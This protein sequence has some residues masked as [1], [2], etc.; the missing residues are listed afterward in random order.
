MITPSRTH[1]VATSWDQAA[2]V[3]SI[4]GQRFNLG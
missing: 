3:A 2:G 1:H 4:Y